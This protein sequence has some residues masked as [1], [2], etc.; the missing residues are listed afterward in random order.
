MKTEPHRGG[1]DEECAQEK[2]VL[3]D[4]SGLRVGTDGADCGSIGLVSG[5]AKD[6]APGCESLASWLPLAFSRNLV[7]LAVKQDQLN[8]MASIPFSAISFQGG[9]R[10]C[11]GIVGVRDE[12]ARDV[13]GPRAFGG[14]GRRH[15]RRN[16]GPSARGEG[17]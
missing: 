3:V 6:W 7:H 14:R 15:C 4:V 1:G 2:D 12:E 8:K 17:E 13:A 10:G 5:W 11:H 9:G 16:A